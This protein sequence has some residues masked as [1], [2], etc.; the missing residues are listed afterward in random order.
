MKIKDMFGYEKTNERL[1]LKFFG[2]KF[3]FRNANYSFDEIAHKYFLQNN[4][5]NDDINA[6]NKLRNLIVAQKLHQE[7]FS[8]YKNCHYGKDV[9]LLETGPSLNDFEPIAN[10]IYVGVNRAYKYNK[11]KLDYLFA[12]D[13]GAIKPYIDKD[14]EEGEGNCTRF[15][16]YFNINSYCQMIIPESLAIKHNAKRYIAMPVWNSCENI[17]YGYE[18]DISCYPL[19][20]NASTVMVAL[21]FILYTNPK[22]IY[23]VGCDCSNL[24]HFDNKNGSFS[25]QYLN[26]LK[27]EWHTFK[28][29]KEYYYPDI[30]IISINPVGLKGLFKDEYQ[31]KQYE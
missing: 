24:G 30:E 26:I 14:F 15:Y 18:P 23:L 29:I 27:D 7:T 3:K 17:R 12:L 4:N 6:N 11:V 21:Q 2:F 1:I 13:F 25:D 9:V 28:K 31:G 20:C 22:R 5:P 10:A 8:Q 19:H 16:G